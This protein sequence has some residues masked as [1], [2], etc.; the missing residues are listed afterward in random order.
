VLN[1][2]VR[3]ETRGTICWR[4][5]GYTS[6]RGST[7]ARTSRPICEIDGRK[8]TAPADTVDRNLAPRDRPDIRIADSKPI[9]AT[10]G[11]TLAAAARRTIVIVV[12]VVSAITQLRT[13]RTDIQVE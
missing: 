6:R 2:A 13:V 7:Y 1:G 5:F 3:P 9:G 12:I 8:P 4:P 10:D 11:L